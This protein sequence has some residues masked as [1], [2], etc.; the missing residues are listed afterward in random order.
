MREG[1][2]SL[3]DYAAAMAGFL[4]M[5]P[6]ILLWLMTLLLGAA[7]GWRIL[8]WASRVFFGWP[9]SSIANPAP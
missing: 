2:N 7:A 4:F 8:R 9:Q 1:L 3:G 5:L 6:T